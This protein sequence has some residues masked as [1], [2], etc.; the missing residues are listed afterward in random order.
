[1]RRKI[2]N[3]LIVNKIN[4]EGWGMGVKFNFFN[5]RMSKEHFEIKE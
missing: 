4:K 5:L 2:L 3:N 1:M